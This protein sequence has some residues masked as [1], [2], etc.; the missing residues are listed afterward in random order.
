MD[1]V[2]RIIVLILLFTFDPFVL[3]LFVKKQKPFQEKIVETL[4]P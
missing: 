4:Q 2:I 1:I 3:S